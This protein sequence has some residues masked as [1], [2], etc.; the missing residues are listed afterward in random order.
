MAILT[1]RVNFLYIAIPVIY[2]IFGRQ[3]IASLNLV[4][5]LELLIAYKWGFVFL[6]IA[7]AVTLNKTTEIGLTTKVNS[8]LIKLYW[9]FALLIAYQFF[10]IDDYPNMEMIFKLALLALAVGLI[11]E[12]FFRGILLYWFRRL[13]DLH[14]ILYSS[15]IFA[16]VHSF[17]L[18][19]GFDI[20]IVALHLLAAFSIG[21]LL[22]ILRLKDKSIVLVIITHTFINYSDFLLNGAKG[23]RLLNLQMLLEW[24]VPSIIFLAWSFYLYANEG[25][26][27]LTTP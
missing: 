14:K 16:L 6:F 26:T 2:L 27:N 19:S 12:I 4:S 17:N 11:E 25:S 1:S 13:S 10:K 15:T 3:M 9:P 18:L 24:L 20:T 22:A 8:S 5:G 21:T 23:E 7:G